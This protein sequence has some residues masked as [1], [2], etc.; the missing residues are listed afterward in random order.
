MSAELRPASPADLDAIDELE[1]R[2][3]PEDAWSR[4][5]IAGELGDA[6]GAYLVAV[7]GDVILGYAGVRAPRGL[8]QADVQTIGL[9]EAARGH[10]LGRTLLRELIRLAIERGAE[11]LFLE[12]RADNTVAQALYASEGFEQIAV[13]PRYYEG[14]HDAWIMRRELVTT[15]AATPGPIGAEALA[16]HPGEAR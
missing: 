14:R 6:N 4:E 1:Q 5:Q 12:V 9:A 7:E 2:I 8:P 10:G 16:A 13:R 15:A 3:F 11:E